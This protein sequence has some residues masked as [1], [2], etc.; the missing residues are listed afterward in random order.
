MNPSA[1]V[2]NVARGTLIDEAALADALAT[3]RL[4]GA[5]L[6]VFTREPLAADSPLWTTPHTI[7]TPHTSAFNGDYW[8][9]A[10]DLFLANWHRFIAGEPLQNRVDSARGY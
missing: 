7:L 5:G 9:P 4:G 2:I 3:G 1:V 6:D 8:T 10:V